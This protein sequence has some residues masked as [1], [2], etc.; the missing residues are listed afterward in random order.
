VINCVTYG[1]DTKVCISGRCVDLD[2][3]FSRDK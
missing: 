1:L 2:E 3:I